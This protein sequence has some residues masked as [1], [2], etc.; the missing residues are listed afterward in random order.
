MDKTIKNNQKLNISLYI[1]LDRRLQAN[2]IIPLIPEKKY[3]K[4]H[5]NRTQKSQAYIKTIKIKN[6]NHLLLLE[7]EK[8]I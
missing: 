2:I 7:R 8:S 6:I 4:T 5:I 3:L 1:L